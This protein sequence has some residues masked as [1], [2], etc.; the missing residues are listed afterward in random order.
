MRFFLSIKLFITTGGS[1]LLPDRSALLL[2]R[3]TG[4]NLVVLPP[5]P[6][7]E[8][9]ELTREELAN[10]SFLVAAS[11]KA[12]LDSLPQLKDGCL[13]YWEAGNWA[14][15]DQADPAGRKKAH[16]FRKMHLHLL[17]RNPNATDPR[18]QW[19]ESPEF[20]KFVERQTYS[21]E[22]Q[23]LTPDECWRIVSQLP[24]ILRA[25][26][27]VPSAEISDPVRCKHCA[28]PTVSNSAFCEESN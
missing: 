19:G 16:D 15:N 2:D 26:Y 17:G 10:F 7:W 24:G 5:R 22:Y 6:V 18:W 4:G 20:P 1:L 11:S 21:A 27:N 12:M 8:R 28:Y 3:F 23:R 14:L 13:N 9:S 25:Q